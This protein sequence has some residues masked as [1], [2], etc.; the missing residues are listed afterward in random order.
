MQPSWV[1]T[2]LQNAAAATGNGSD[3]TLGGLGGVL[4]AISGTFTGTVAFEAQGPDGAYYSVM[5]TK[6]ADWS[7][8]TS[9]TTAGIWFFALPGARSFRAPVTWTSGTSVTVKAAAVP[10]Y[11]H[12]GSS[13]LSTGDLEI[14]AVEIKNATTDTRAVV[15]A[16][17]TA[18]QATDTP[19]VVALHPSSPV[20]PGTA[21]TSLGKAEDAAHTSGDVGVEMLGVRNDANA[22][23]TTTDLDY[24]P[25][26]TDSAGRMKLA[27]GALILGSVGIDQTTPGTTNNVANA[28][29]TNF[30][31]GEYETVAASQTAQALGSTGAIGDYISGLLV[32]PA[33]LNPGNVILLDNAIS[34]T[35]FTGGTGSVSNLIPFFIPLGLKSVSGALK[36]TTGADVSV[37]AIGNFT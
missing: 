32:I 18:A 35:V 11:S 17:S 3:I 6:L 1:E 4:V 16:A 24:S 14:G 20:P 29:L 13:I 21:A 25:I 28:N 22:V 23:L 12:V 9:T 33:T 36:V 8:G 34:M 30:G 19:L 37:I 10:N 31:A 27:A 2:T 5:G 7:T 15:L 26:A